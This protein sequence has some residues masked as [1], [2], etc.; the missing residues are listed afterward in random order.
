MGE[1]FPKDLR[2]QQNIVFQLD[3]DI[4]LF[5]IQHDGLLPVMVKLNALMGE[6]SKAVNLQFGFCLLFY[7]WQYF[8]FYAAN[9]VSFT[10]I[11]GKN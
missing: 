7:L 5:I 4:T 8:F 9:F 1:L 3:I 10:N 2:S 6:M 11:L